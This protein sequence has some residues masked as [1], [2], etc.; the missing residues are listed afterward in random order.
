MRKE[1]RSLPAT[2][3]S[4]PSWPLRTDKPERR[5]P[6]TI[7]EEV[8]G[9]LAGMRNELLAQRANDLRDV[10]LRVLSILTGEVRQPEF[11]PNTV[12]SLI[13]DDFR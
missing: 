3:L 5:V 7:A 1:L 13:A 4:V 6:S 12:L 9:R 8:L 2:R 10:G 11:A